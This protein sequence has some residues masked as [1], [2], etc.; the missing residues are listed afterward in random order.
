MHPNAPCHEPI[1]NIISTTPACESLSNEGCAR[2]MMPWIATANIHAITKPTEST[3][4]KSIERKRSSSG[5]LQSSKSSLFR[6]IHCTYNRWRRNVKARKLPMPT[7]QYVAMCDCLCGLSK[8]T[9]YPSGGGI[10]T[11]TPL[12]SDILATLFLHR[13]GD[14]DE[15]SG[16]VNGSD[17]RERRATEYGQ[18]RRPNC[19]KRSAVSH[20]RNV[21]LEEL[22]VRLIDKHTPTS[23][24]HPCL[25]SPMADGQGAA[26]KLIFV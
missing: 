3:V 16:Q 11:G 26:D 2:V 13:C 18:G 19:E 24:L 15:R 10:A 17:H 4:R 23:E 25:I 12:T 22:A 1:W 6:T 14:L 21:A 20:R 9:T 8:S 7:M 5:I